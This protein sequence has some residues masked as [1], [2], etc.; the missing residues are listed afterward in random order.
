MPAWRRALIRPLSR[1]AMTQE[2][3]HPITPPPELIGRWEEDWH[4][5]KVKHIELE[6]HIANEAAQW[7]ANQELEACCEWL[8]RNYN[9]P[10]AG[11]PL[12]TARRPKP[13]SAVAQ[14]E[15]LIER[16][17]DGW[18]P[19]PAQWHTIREGLAEGRRAL[20]AFNAH[21]RKERLAIAA[22]LD[23]TNLTSE[24]D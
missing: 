2:Q 16:H 23:G 10:E 4:H 13:P 15:T 21:V 5:S 24:G 14:A 18:V 12:R 3:Q 17:E 11:N 8:V 1:T 19:S 6:D 9:Y 20:E 7:G 22:E